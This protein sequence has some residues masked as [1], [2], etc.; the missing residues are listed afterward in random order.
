M[1]VSIYYCITHLAL[2]MSELVAVAE[3]QKLTEPIVSVM[4]TTVAV[5]AVKADR[6]LATIVRVHNILPIDG[7]DRIVL[8][9]INGW[10][11]VVKKDEF[12]IGDFVIYFCVDS[13]PDFSDANMK[14]LVDMGI[15]R[16]KTIR[17]RGTISQ[18]LLGPLQWLTDRGHD[19][20]T[21]VEGDNVTEQMGVTK[22]VHEEEMGQY[23]GGSRGLGEFC[24]SWPA[25]IPKTDE[26]RLQNNLK[27]LSELVGRDIVITRKEDGCSCTFVFHEG[28]FSVCSRNMV[29]LQGNQNSGH[30]FLLENKFKVGEKMTNLGRQLAI[31]GEAIG[32]KI[33]G[34]KL[35]LTEHTFRVFNIFDIVEQRYL[36]HDEVS[37]ICGI[38]GL[39]Q[40]PVI[41]KGSAN[42][43]TFADKVFETLIK[44]ET[45]GK[46]LILAELLKLADEQE[47]SKGDHAEGIVVK[48]IDR[49]G[50]RVSFKVISNEFLLVNDK[51]V[52]AKKAKK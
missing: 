43:L 47:Y 19:V 37:E 18:G 4:P 29:I 39:D 15:K 3:E 24:E 13:I 36:L 21:L 12:K 48:T 2:N 1:L 25:N 49:V 51:D 14:F 9:E 40:V 31:Q 46:Q 35:K 32:P 8:A 11:C 50:G 23:E 5:E 30:Y 16:I 45:T 42:G 34:N 38:L 20:T 7:A 22:Y 33:N 52:K 27:Y 10:R 44:N 28:K 26:D 6:P 41:Y 17:M